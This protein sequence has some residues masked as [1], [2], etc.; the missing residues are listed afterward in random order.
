MRRARNIAMA[1]LAAACLVGGPAPAQEPDLRGI[2]RGLNQ[3][4]ARLTLEL[5]REDWDGVARTAGSIADHPPIP[6]AQAGAIRERLGE[7]MSGFVELDREVHDEAV[8]IRESAKR[9]DA[10][11]VLRHT[12]NMMRGCVACHSAYREKLRGVGG[13]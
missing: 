8:A 5:M 7:G 12:Q 1:G 10:D 11:A 2:M 3:D 13:Q 6:E 4:L 9:E